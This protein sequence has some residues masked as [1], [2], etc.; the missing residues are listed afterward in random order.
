MTILEKIN[1][2]GA[3]ILAIQA[4]IIFVVAYHRQQSLHL[5]AFFVHWGIVWLCLFIFYLLDLIYE[6]PALTYVGM[7]VDTIGNFALAFAAYALFRADQFNWS[8][9][10]L[11][12]GYGILPIVIVFNIA[13]YVLIPN[14]DIVWIMFYNSPNILMAAGCSIAIGIGLFR[15]PTAKVV[16]WPLMIVF[17]TYAFLQI[18]AYYL[19]FLKNVPELDASKNAMSVFLA[20]GKFVLIVA[21]TTMAISNTE[22]GSEK[23]VKTIQI[24]TWILTLGFSLYILLF[25]L[26]QALSLSNG[27]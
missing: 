23:F 7:S 13:V 3:T 9:R 11:I 5:Q 4:F 15:E 22:I 25:R 16:R 1:F 14:S 26:L 18:P 12:Y 20:S 8:D 17:L 19:D 6:T 2:A 27:G 10:L 21:F 24:A